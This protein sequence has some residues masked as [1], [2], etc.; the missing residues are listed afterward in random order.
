M[1]VAAPEPA[2]VVY[3]AA[4]AEQSRTPVPVTADDIA[5]S[6]AQHRVTPVTV[7]SD[8]RYL[9]VGAS[10]IAIR[11]DDLTVSWTMNGVRGTP[12]LVGD[13][14]LVPVDAGLAVVAVTDGTVTSTLPVDRGGYEGTVDVGTVGN[15]VVESRAS[16]VVGLRDPAAPATDPPLTTGPRPSATLPSAI[17]PTGEPVT[18]SGSVSAP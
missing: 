11:T 14:L 16:T 5:T 12:A 4:G 18:G 15:T 13:S 8:A 17:L 9:Q 6:L 3:D 10:L 2:V 1:L 7:T